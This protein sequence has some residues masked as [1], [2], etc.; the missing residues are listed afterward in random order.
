MNS[1]MRKEYP[2]KKIVIPEYIKDRTPEE[3]KLTLECTEH[4]TAN[5]VRGRRP[6]P[7]SK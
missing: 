3:R 4:I 5:E 7:K 6:R 1:N 2:G